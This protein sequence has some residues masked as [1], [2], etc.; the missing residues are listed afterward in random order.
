MDGQFQIGDLVRVTEHYERECGRIGRVTD[1]AIVIKRHQEAHGH[2][3][4]QG[5]MRIDQ[6]GSHMYWIE[7]IDGAAGRP[8]A[9]EIDEFALSR[10]E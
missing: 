4:Y 1:P 5:H 10:V 7:F 2:G 9:T 6:S 8:T 3:K